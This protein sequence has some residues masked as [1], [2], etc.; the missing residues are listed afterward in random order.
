MAKIVE[1]ASDSINTCTRINIHLQYTWDSTEHV[2][3]EIFLFIPPL[4]SCGASTDQMK[5]ETGIC[6]SNNFLC[7]CLIIWTYQFYHWFWF[8]IHVVR[9]QE[10]ILSLIVSSDLINS[11]T[12]SIVQCLR[13]NIQNNFWLVINGQLIVMYICICKMQNPSSD[14]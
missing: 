1:H 10:V 9:T 14:Y 6:K 8:K 2:S 7:K 12:K 13:V 3:P 11:V 5:S 4:C